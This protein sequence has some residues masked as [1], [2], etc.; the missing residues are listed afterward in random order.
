[1]RFWLI[2][3]FYCCVGIL[4]FAK[5]YYTSKDMTGSFIRAFIWP[6]AQ[7]PYIKGVVMMQVD[8]LVQMVQGLM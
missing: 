7:W 6:Y 4:F 2:Q 8:R 5:D 3:S 1:M